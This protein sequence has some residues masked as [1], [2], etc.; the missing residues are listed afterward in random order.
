[1]VQ[2]LILVRRRT[3]MKKILRCCTT[4]LSHDITGLAQDSTGYLWA[5]AAYGLNRFNGNNFAPI[6][7]Q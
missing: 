7:Q 6:S 3:W 5:T 4:S 1:M 2:L